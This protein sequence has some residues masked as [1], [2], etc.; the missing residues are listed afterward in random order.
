MSKASYSSTSVGGVFYSLHLFLTLLSIGGV[1]YL[2]L[3]LRELQ[4]EVKKLKQSGALCG[5]KNTVKIESDLGSKQN[6]SKA[7]NQI[8]KAGNKR[9]KRAFDSG[10]T[11]NQTCVKI[12]H[13]FMKL[14]EESSLLVCIM[15]MVWSLK[16]SVQTL[17]AFIDRRMVVHVLKWASVL[18]F[19]YR[20]KTKQTVIIQVVLSV[21]PVSA[22]L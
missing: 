15:L 2:L 4:N 7:F 5:L 6:G 14:L 22:L 11:E 17:I 13:D 9:N 19:E 21:F 10:T 8:L 18:L 16:K 3:S 1:L 20:F 12:V